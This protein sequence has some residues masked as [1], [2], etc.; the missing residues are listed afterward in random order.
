LFLA[1]VVSNAVAVPF[2]SKKS[3]PP[4]ILLILADDMGYGDLSCY[5]A[6][7][8]LTPNIDR[9]AGFPVSA[10]LRAQRK[11]HRLG[12]LL[13]CEQKGFLRCRFLR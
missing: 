12:F 13:F 1:A 7:N 5:G 11:H 2:F 3:E 8:I 6:T 10:E 9:I 4:N